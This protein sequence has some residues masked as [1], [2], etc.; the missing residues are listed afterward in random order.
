[1]RSL[2]NP[3]NT[4]KK[5]YKKSILR[6][7]ANDKIPFPVAIRDNATISLFEIF[8][9]N[10]MLLDKTQR[11]ER[12]KEMFNLTD[13]GTFKKLI[14]KLLSKGYIDYVKYGKRKIIY[15]TPKGVIALKNVKKQLKRREIKHEL[16]KT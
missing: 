8:L 12:I 15:L 3:K 2:E 14:H 9:E 4:T 7:Y 6:K 10:K 1:M 5:T 11:Y 13:K 16:V